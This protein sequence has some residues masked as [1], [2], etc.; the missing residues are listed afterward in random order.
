MLST[1]PSPCSLTRCARVQRLKHGCTIKASAKTLLLPRWKKLIDYGY[2]NDA[3]Y[4]KEY[5]HVRSVSGKIRP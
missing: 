5:V 2:I 4:A 3:A 1:V